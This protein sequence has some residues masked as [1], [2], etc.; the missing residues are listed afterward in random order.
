MGGGGIRTC[1]VIVQ[2][3]RHGS[4]DSGGQDLRGD[5]HGPSVQLTCNRHLQTPDPHPG[6]QNENMGAKHPPIGDVP[7]N[8]FQSLH[9][10]VNVEA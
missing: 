9:S 7:G 3:E 2:I 1:D 10:G 4:D 6:P 8:D 5:T